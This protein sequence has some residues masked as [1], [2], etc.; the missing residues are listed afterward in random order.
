MEKMIREILDERL[1]WTLDQKIDHAVGVVEE[2]KNKTGKIPYVSFS[3]GKDSTVLLDL[4]RRFVDKDMAAVFCNTGNEYPEIVKFVKTFDNITIIRPKKKIKDVIEKYGFPIVSKEQSSYIRQFKHTKS[5]KT[6]DRLLGDRFAISR[7]W[8][9]LLDV[10]FD[11]SE[12][13]CFYLKKEPFREFNKET[14]MLP[15][16]GIMAGESNLRRTTYINRGGCNSFD[17]KMPMS[18]PL[19]I[20]TEK[21]IYDYIE[22]FKLPICSLYTEHGFTRTG[23]AFCGFGAHNKGD[24]RFEQLK[25]LH[26]K[27]F[28]HVLNYKN[29]GITYGQA[30]QSVG[31]FVNTFDFKD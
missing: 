4:C 29:H 12:K 23:C 20:W 30:L 2:F 27:L 17:T 24:N 15:V 6:I 1:N 7:K 5:Q 16:L 25:T 10:P 22:R 14:G 9:Y 31:V 18:Y 13:C 3:G 26:P 11:I 28:N 19:S 21:D 8:R